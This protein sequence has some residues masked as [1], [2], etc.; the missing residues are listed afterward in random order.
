TSAL[1][2]ELPSNVVFIGAM[3]PDAAITALPLPED[4]PP[5][6]R[7]RKRGERLPAPSDLAKAASQRWRAVDVHNSGQDTTLE[8]K[9]YDVHWSRDARERHAR[10][11]PV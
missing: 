5:T 8:I 10:M 1:L 2:A 11:V 9:V 7:R 4:Q 6:G 3:R